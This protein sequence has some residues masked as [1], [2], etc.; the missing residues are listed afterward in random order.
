MRNLLLIALLFASCGINRQAQ[1]IKT[2]EKCEY[3]FISAKNITL[4]DADV[5]QIIN[6]GQIDL[7][8]TPAIALGFL[9]KNI[10]L[11]AT[12]NLEIANPSAVLAG[13][14]HFEY[15]I[16]INRQDVA[17][18]TM[19]QAISIEPGQKTM[20]PIQINANVYQFLT[21][22]KVRNEIIDFIEV[23]T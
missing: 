7:S 13:I 4:A 5:G 10:P 8:K 1:Q 18:G 14:N 6:N 17:R 23:I 20:V 22:E 3:R 12:L 21:N 11:R 2:L 15:I 9:R 16:Q 19:N